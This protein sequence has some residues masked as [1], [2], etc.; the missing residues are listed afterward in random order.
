MNNLMKHNSYP[1]KRGH[2]VVGMS[3][4]VDS[5]VTVHLL[6]EQGYNV[7]GVTMKIWD[8]VSFP[9][10]ESKRS[11]FGPYESLR[12]K[13][14]EAVARYLDIPFQVIDVSSD[15]RNTV[16]D[17]FSFD[18]MNGRTPNPCVICNRYIKFA[19][20][21]LKLRETGIQ[22]D[23]FATGHYARITYDESCKRFLL[24]RGKDL[25]KDQ[26][27]F[28]HLLTQ[29]QLAHTL[30]PLGEM[31]KEE[32]RDIG[33]SIN[34][35][36]A[37]KSESQDFISTD[38][39]PSLF[40]DKPEP[41]PIFDSA[42]NDLGQHRGIIHYTIGQRKGLRLA[43][44]KPRYVIKID[45]EKNALVIGSK[46]ETYSNRLIAKNINWIAFDSLTESMRVKT[47]IRFKHKEAD[48]LLE[49]INDTSVQVIFDE[50]Q[51][52]I[53]PGQMAV[54]YN[55]DTVLGG[56]TIVSDSPKFQS[57]LFKLND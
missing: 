39:Y 30:F 12:I 38:Q 25:H 1:Q 22:F 11:C 32:V 29:E 36:V 19:L 51:S 48:S 37:E 43:F 56:G 53:T 34:L 5:S 8:G 13:E 6:K 55:D 18:Y 16:L 40:S 45:A 35:S 33:R 17:Y 4:G 10:K 52:A 2:V 42:G 47:R 20:L 57:R 15:Y 26:S 46:K 41:G 7:T 9:S 23:Y 21:P 14:T 50:P 31:K 49:P 54:F 27:Y 24:K 3:G 28:L 44:G